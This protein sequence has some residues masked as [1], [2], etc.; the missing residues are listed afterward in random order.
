MNK[1]KLFP[2]FK[3]CRK[4]TL[5]ELL[6]VIAIIAILAAMLLPALSAARGRAKAALCTSNM[7]QIT[8]AMFAYADDNNNL[9]PQNKTNGKG[10]FS[11]S[12]IY[13][14]EKIFSYTGVDP[15]E[16]A[17][18]AEGSKGNN[19]FYCPECE[20][21]TGS[22]AYT[23]FGYNSS[24]CGMAAEGTNTASYCGK[25]LTV[26]K[27]PT[28]T[29]ILVENGD[30]SGSFP[31]EA[32]AGSLTTFNCGARLTAGNSVAALAYPHS[33]GLHVSMADGHVEWRPQPKKDK[34]LELEGVIAGDQTTR[35]QMY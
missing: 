20:K 6:V 12:K 8:Q 25:N 31:A 13:W 1:I 5:I 29:F 16:L 19:I 11:T 2:C 9:L 4:F 17:N 33:V 7:R 22:N 26:I 34:A 27:N 14:T 10:V 30:K 35:C 23:S 21:N 32:L 28:N 3:P 24:F 18:T 15:K